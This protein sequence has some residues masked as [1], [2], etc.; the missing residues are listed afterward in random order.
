[1]PDC[2][3]GIFGG[4]KEVAV[5]ISHRGIASYRSASEWQRMTSQFIVQPLSFW[6]MRFVST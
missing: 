6:H 5:Q 1:V 3:L 2:R 4:Q